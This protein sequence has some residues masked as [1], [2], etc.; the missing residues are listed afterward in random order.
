MSS[1]PNEIFL[2]ILLKLPVKS[3]LVSCVGPIY[4]PGLVIPVIRLGNFEAMILEEVQVD[5]SLI[6]YNQK[7]IMGLA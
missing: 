6:L 5:R 7:K 2:E 4:F 3:T 1:T